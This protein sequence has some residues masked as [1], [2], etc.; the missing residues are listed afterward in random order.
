MV[1][2]ELEAV[3]SIE[4]IVKLTERCNINCTYCYFFN[5]GDEDYKKHPPLLSTGTA[6]AIADFLKQGAQELGAKKIIIDFHG[7]E[8]LLMKQHR[9]AEICD[10]FASRLAGE[11]KLNF[12][13][14]TN[15][16][17]VDEEWIA[18]FEKYRVM[19]GVSIDGPMEYN[20]VDRVD[21]DGKGTYER[22]AAGIRRLHEAT[23]AGRIPPVGALCVINPAFS[24]KKIYRHFIDELGFGGVN[25]LMPLD[26]YDEIKLKPGI[27]KKYGEFLCE[28]FDEYVAD[29]NP[30][31]RIRVLQSAMMGLA[32]GV[33]FAADRQEK[34]GWAHQAFV[35]SSNGDLGPDDTL[36]NAHAGFF[37]TGSN[38]STVTLKQYLNLEMNKMMRAAHS[39]LNAQCE[40]CCWRNIC[41]GGDM[42]NRYNKRNGF[43]NPSA[44]CD[45][46]QEFISHVCAYLLRHGLSQQ[47]L[48]EV[49]DWRPSAE[50]GRSQIEALA[51]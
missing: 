42:I 13:L 3:S 33:K 49:V 40:S 35:V 32:G 48:M 7:G 46:W 2:R 22:V 21:H 36:R 16:M 47:T 8:P 10:I 1:E 23:A 50:T 38:V 15:G 26:T 12:K 45:G 4:A 29:D 24:A 17:L 44:L 11:F 27:A 6:E 43:D 28:L 25:F 20:D 14:Q 19:I 18:L 5:G 9:F 30:A 51:C 41:R 37:S 39:T 31:I 34:I